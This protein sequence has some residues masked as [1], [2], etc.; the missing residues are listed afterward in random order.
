MAY[1]GSSNTNASYFSCEKTS[2]NDISTLK[3]KG[4][5]MEIELY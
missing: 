1:F 5:Y 2:R 4:L 3:R